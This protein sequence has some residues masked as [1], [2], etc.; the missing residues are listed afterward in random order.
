MSVA[1]ECT[2][3]ETVR[4]QVDGCESYLSF[5]LAYLKLVLGQGEK[6]GRCANV[7]TRVDETSGSVREGG[8]I[9]GWGGG[10]EYF[11][12][13]AVFA[14]MFVQI[15]VCSEQRLCQRVGWDVWTLS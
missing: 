3:K 4:E 7:S 5:F 1:N 12:S 2:I 13:G 11:K 10:K 9:G 15:G 6:L 14:E 8:G